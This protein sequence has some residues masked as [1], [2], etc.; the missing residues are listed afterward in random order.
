MATA[1][2]HPTDSVEA[3]LQKMW[4]LIVDDNNVY[5]HGWIQCQF[6]REGRPEMSPNCANRAV[7]GEKYCSE[8]M[9]RTP[10]RALWFLF[11]AVT[12]IVFVL[13]RAL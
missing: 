4:G 7:I 10:S 3:E 1:T 12:T 9:P 8:H 13:L 5:R 6:I 11:G 2:T